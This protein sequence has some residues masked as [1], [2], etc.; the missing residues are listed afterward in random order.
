MQSAFGRSFSGVRVHT[1]ATASRLSD[2]F[3]ARAFTIGQHVAFGAGEY[4]PGTLMGDALVAHELADVAQQGNAPASVAQMQIGSSATGGLERDADRSSAAA[5]ASLWGGAARGLGGFARKAVPRLRSGLSIQ[6]CKKETCSEGT[7][8]IAVDLV[9]LDGSTRSPATDLAE[10]NKIYKKCCVQFTVGQQP[11]AVSNALTTGWLG[12]D[13]DVAV[14]PGCG[15]VATEEKDMYDKATAKYTLSSTMRAFYVKSFS[16][17]AA[18]G[19]SIPPYCASGAA[20]PYVN[21]IVLQ[22]NVRNSALAH[23]LGHILLNSGKHELPPNL[24]EPASGT[25]ISDAQCK[26]IYNNV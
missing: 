14:A 15:S 6:R 9:T 10:A 1:G 3:N 25:V 17:H 16:G 8:T 19:Y 20:G 12:G 18:G 2:R 5:V 21:H 13:T 22:N 23:E 7:K 24:M 26:T 4:R 11:A